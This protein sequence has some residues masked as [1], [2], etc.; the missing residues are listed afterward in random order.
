MS[1]R[2]LNHGP[3]CCTEITYNFSKT[4]KIFKA[5]LED[6][7]SHHTGKREVLTNIPINESL[8]SWNTSMLDVRSLFL[9]YGLHKLVFRFQVETYTPEVVM[10]KEA[11]TYVNITKSPLVAIMIA[12][13]VS[14]IARYGHYF[15]R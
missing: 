11:Y 13:S 7:P 5:D 14:Q 10:F 9:N 6:D 15:I 1:D 12:G 4:W 3:G 2:T 8:A